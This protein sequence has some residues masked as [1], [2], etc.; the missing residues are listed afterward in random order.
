[1]KSS[2]ILMKPIEVW[3]WDHAPPEY[4]LEGVSNAEFL[5]LVPEEYYYRYG[6]P[7][8]LGA[9]ETTTFVHEDGYLIVCH[10]YATI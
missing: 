2:M 5:A 3:A 1:M 6:E 4:K 7:E 10:N 8:F 9:W